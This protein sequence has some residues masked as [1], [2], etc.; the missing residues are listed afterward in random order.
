MQKE[1]V[2]FRN[3]IITTNTKLSDTNVLEYR[4]INLSG[5]NSVYINGIQIEPQLSILYFANALIFNINSN[6]ND[7][8]IYNVT[9]EDAFNANNRCLVIQKMRANYK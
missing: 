5:T 1:D 2:V 3:Q 8:T 7:C 9:F 4:F 6:E